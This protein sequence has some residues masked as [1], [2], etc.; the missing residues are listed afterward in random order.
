MNLC[1][2]CGCGCDLNADVE[3]EGIG[4]SGF[5]CG[6]DGCLRGRVFVFVMRV[7]SLSHCHMLKVYI[8]LYIGKMRSDTRRYSKKG[9][10]TLLARSSI[11]LSS[12]KYNQPTLDRYT[13][14]TSK[15]TR[16]KLKLQRCAQ[17]RHPPIIPPTHSKHLARKR[18]KRQI[19]TIK[20]CLPL[21]RSPQHMHL[22]NPY[23]QSVP[24]ANQSPGP[25][26]RHC[27]SMQPLRQT[28]VACSRRLSFPARRTFA[29]QVQS[30]V[31]VTPFLPFPRP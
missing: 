18:E 5:G 29:P 9:K 10:G 3:I 28:S 21:T 4:M 14:K 12:V 20:P 27:P 26:L 1:D 11:H 17:Q 7:T 30:F 6:R 24:E 23:P 16:T 2:D 8:L 31:P 25:D 19:S 13:E 22:G 15:R